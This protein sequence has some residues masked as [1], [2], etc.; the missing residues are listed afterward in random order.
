VDYVMIRAWGQHMGSHSYYI[1]DQIAIAKEDKAP[2]NAIYKRDDG[3]WATIDDIK[4]KPVRDQI[5]MLAAAIQKR[6]NPST[7][8]IT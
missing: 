4:N 2:G 3:T 6:E 5:D 1:R 8:R 7:R